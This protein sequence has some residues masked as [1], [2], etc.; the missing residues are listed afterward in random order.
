MEK[1]FKLNKKISYVIHVFLCVVFLL[2]CSPKIYKHEIEKACE[3]CKERNGVLYITYDVTEFY[4]K[5][6]DGHSERFN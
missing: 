5:C 1:Y 6:N 2:G 4:V 3:I